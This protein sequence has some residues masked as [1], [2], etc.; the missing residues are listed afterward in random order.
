MKPLSLWLI[1]LSV[2]A[3]FLFQ[4]C[5]PKQASVRST[6]YREFRMGEAERYHKPINLQI[7]WFPYEESRMERM[8]NGDLVVM[9]DSLMTT[10]AMPAIVVSYTDT[11]H[12]VWLD[13]DTDDALLGQ[14]IKYS[15]MTEAPISEPFSEYLQAVDCSDCHPKGLNIRR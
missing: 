8:E 3:A 5:S 1:V 14:L 9:K 12:L 4:A 15:L 2:P 11:T 10:G 7:G 13:V 6:R